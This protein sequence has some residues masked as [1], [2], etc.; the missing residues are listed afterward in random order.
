MDTLSKRAA[1]EKLLRT[2]L[3]GILKLLHYAL[4]FDNETEDHHDSAN[5]VFRL[6][7]KGLKT[8][9]VCNDDWRDYTEYF[10]VK[11]DGADIL[12]INIS[13]YDDVEKAFELVELKLWQKLNE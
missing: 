4:V 10:Q 6:V 13:E 11:C 8:V 5:W 2:K 3:T 12:E 1:F 9:E 7:Y